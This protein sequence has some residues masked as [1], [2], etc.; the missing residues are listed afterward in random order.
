MTNETTLNGV[1]I[2]YK[3]KSDKP[4]KTDKKHAVDDSKKRT[5][6][7]KGQSKPSRPY[8]NKSKNQK[9]FVQDKAKKTPTNNYAKLASNSRFCAIDI[10]IKVE[11]GQSLTELL[12]TEMHALNDS[13]KRF[14]QHLVY[15]ALRQFEILEFQLTH[16]L[17]KPIK[18]SERQVY[19]ALLLAI[20]EITTMN[21]A[22]YAAVNN[23]VD[24]IRLMDKDWAIGLTNGILRKVLREGLQPLPKNTA[25]VSLPKWLSESLIRYWGVENACAIAEHFLT[26]PQMTIRVNPLQT[27]RDQYSEFLT[28]NSVEHEKHAF[29]DS[30]IVLK[31]AVSVSNLPSFF[32]GMSSVQDASAQLAALLLAPKNNEVIIDAC[33]APGGKTIAMLERNSELKTIYAVD[34]VEKRLLRV[35]ENIDRVFPKELAEKIVLTAKPYE[36][37]TVEGEVDAI[38]LDVPCSATGIIHRHP[39]IKRLRQADDIKVLIE[40]Q[41]DLLEHAWNEL[42]VG[43]RL[44]YATC[45]ILKDENEYQ[46]EYFFENTQNAKE[47]ELDL[48]F[49]QREKY[50]Y[51]IL[52]VYSELSEK[53][54]GFYYCLIEKAHD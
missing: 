23:W 41:Y 13:D 17:Q 49:A 31:E 28:Q 1:K 20:Y 37:F 11:K 54:D 35:Q 3:P 32:E 12:T 19:I 8:A 15:G 50:G 38:L 33:A 44:L 22:E 52:P 24:L 6:Y 42:K 36:D 43:G 53:M 47:I 45:S 29:V 21:T 30:A 14:V 9:S 4:A 51:Q 27:D 10:V 7:D 46:M 16:Y 48:P 5:Y 40:T 34:S 25:K 26:H 2:S 39:D 18:P